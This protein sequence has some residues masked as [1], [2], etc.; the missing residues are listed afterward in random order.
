MYGPWISGFLV[1]NAACCPSGLLGGCI[2]DQRPC[3]NR[4]EYVFWDE[5]HPTEAWNLFPALTSFDASSNP[6]FT[7]PMDIKHLV[8]Q[9]FKMELE[10]KNEITSQLS[11]PE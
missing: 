7:Y 5:F 11:A 4:S 3:D 8:D 9:E 2:P 6:S 10:L 1:S